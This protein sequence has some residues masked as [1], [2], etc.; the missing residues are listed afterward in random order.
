MVLFLDGIQ[1]RGD[2]GAA[3]LPHTVV[4]NQRGYRREMHAEAME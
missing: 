4:F 1:E 2:I 3:G